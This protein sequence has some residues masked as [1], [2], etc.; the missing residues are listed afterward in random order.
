M[1]FKLPFLQAMRQ[2]APKMFN[3]LSREGTLMAFV[4]EKA[5]EAQRMFLELTATA[6]K[7]PTGYPKEPE[8][9]EAAEQVMALMLDFPNHE[10]TT[11]QMDERSA[12][13]DQPQT[14]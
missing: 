14:Q 12:L 10:E 4:D 11:R 8:A 9:R 13:L 7:D 1:E 6:P 3:R 5:A 2:Q